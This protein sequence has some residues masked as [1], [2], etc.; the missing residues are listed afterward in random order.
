MSHWCPAGLAAGFVT[1]AKTMAVS[2]L[3]L[4]ADDF[5]AAI[6]AAKRLKLLNYVA[7]AVVGV[8]MLTARRRTGRRRDGGGP[9]AVLVRRRGAVDDDVR[10][11]AQQLDDPDR[12]RLGLGRVP[13][14]VEPAR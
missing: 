7:A 11:D 5:V 2:Q 3:L 10:A 6:P 14:L 12:L 1:K 13:E 9:G 4:D 8:T